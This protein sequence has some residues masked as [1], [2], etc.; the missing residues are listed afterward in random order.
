MFLALAPMPIVSEDPDHPGLPVP[1][2]KQWL[3]SL[4]RLRQLELSTIYPGHGP[5]FDKAKQVMERQLKRID[6]R[7]QEC[8]EAIKSGL[9]TAYDINREMYSYQKLPPDFSG[10]FMTLGYLDLLVSENRI[11]VKTVNNVSK[12][13]SL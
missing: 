13:Y 5:T 8:Y 11:E 7:K 6:M 10:L 1:A 4:D 9:S 12:Y 2:L 3:Q